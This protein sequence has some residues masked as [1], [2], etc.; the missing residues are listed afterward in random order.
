MQPLLLP[1]LDVVA[2]SVVF[3]RPSVVV[4]CNCVISMAMVKFDSSLFIS[5]GVFFIR[6]MLNIE[7]FSSVLA[8]KTTWS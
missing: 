1:G 8:T 4:S 2:S 7:P 3:M 6:L 5:F